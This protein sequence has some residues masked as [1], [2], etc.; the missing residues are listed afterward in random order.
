MGTN[1]LCS[2]LC[3]LP[4]RPI[5]HFLPKSLRVEIAEESNKYRSQCNHSM[6]MDQY[7]RIQLAQQKDHSISGPTLESIEERLH[8]HR[9]FQPHEFVYFIGLHVTRALSPM[10]DGIAKHWVSCEDDALPR[11]TWSCFMKRSRYVE[12]VRFLHFADNPTNVGPHDKAWEIRPIL[13]VGETTFRR[14]YRLGRA[15]SFDKGMVPNKA[16][17]T[18]YERTT[19]INQFFLTSCAKT[20]YCTRHTVAKQ[21]RQKPLDQQLWCAIFPVKRL[22]VTDNYYS[23]VALSLMLLTMGLYHVGSMRANRLGW[24]KSIH[25]TQKNARR[26]FQEERIELLRLLITQNLPVNML[27][28]SVLRTENDGSRSVPCPIVVTEYLSGMGSVDT[29]TKFDFDAILFKKPVALRNITCNCFSD[30]LIWP[31]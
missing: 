29:M 26:I 20:A 19:R 23:S 12:L 28:T 21:K 24:C 27:A 22:I 9:P 31:W 2:S 10:R 8:R 14:A 4:S 18:H 15:I 6:A 13:Q 11:G 17:S 5:F 25:Y 16:A 3:R 1:A 7:K 30:W